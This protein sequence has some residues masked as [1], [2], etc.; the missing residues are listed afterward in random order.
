[1]LKLLFLDID[2]VLNN[3]ND[4]DPHINEINGEWAPHSSFNISNLNLVLKHTNAK[5]VISSTW[6]LGRTLEELQVLCKDMGIKGE[7]IGKTES[8][9]SVPVSLRGLEILHFIENNK[10]LIGY[11]G[12]YRDYSSYVILDDDSDMLY[13]QKDNFIKINPNIGLSPYNAISAIRILNKNEEFYLLNPVSS[14]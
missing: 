12:F 5:I 13:W 8:M 6:R 2:G 14:V 7:I 10:K 11:E 3:V 9:H 4:R 1:M